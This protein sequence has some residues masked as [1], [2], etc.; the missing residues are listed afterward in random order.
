M[1]DRTLRKRYEESVLSEAVDPK[2]IARISALLDRLEQAIPDG[3][4]TFQQALEAAK[5]DVEKLVQGGLLNKIKTTI[6]DPVAKATLL[7]NAVRNGMSQLPTVA[8]LYVPKG[9][10]SQGQTL[11]ELTPETKRDG[12]VKA[13]VNVFKPKLEDRIADDFLGLVRGNQLPYIKDLK[14]AVQE[15]LQ[16]LTPANAP[17]VAQAAANVGTVE[18]ETAAPEPGAKPGSEPAGR[19]RLSNA[20][21]TAPAAAEQT[22]AAT[23]ATAGPTPAQKNLQT[24]VPRKLTANDTQ[25][26]DD[27]VDFLTNAQR[28]GSPRLGVDRKAISQVLAALAKNGMLVA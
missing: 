1:R 25:Q 6:A 24:N 3:V 19:A 22:S 10:E 27:I 9:S 16:H 11:W 5:A 20:K 26:M 21:Q 18:V 12:M 4:P 13:F 15:L 17:Q 7:A 8:R 14:L 23:Q 28:P 2:E